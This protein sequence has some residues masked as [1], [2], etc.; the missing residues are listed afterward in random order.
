MCG[1]V[2]SWHTV[3]FG[4]LVQLRHWHDSPT[5]WGTI[6]S[7]EKVLGTYKPIVCVSVACGPRLFGPGPMVGP[8]G[9]ARRP[10]GVDLNPVPELQGFGFSVFRL[11]F[12]GF[13]IYILGAHLP[14]II[15]YHELFC[16]F[17]A[18]I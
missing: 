12:L 11:T 13:W 16:S 10:M 18:N 8:A 1:W 15:N 5:Q 17:C 4:V 2:V 6:I 9:L 3:T 14:Q 7:R